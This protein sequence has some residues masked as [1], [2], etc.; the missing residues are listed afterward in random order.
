MS[1]LSCKPKNERFFKLSDTSSFCASQIKR[2]TCTSWKGG[3]E[4]KGAWH[5]NELLITATA[6]HVV[7]SSSGRND[8]ISMYCQ[9]TVKHLIPGSTQFNILQPPFDIE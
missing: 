7:T 1:M 8:V 4:N 9:L 6:L 3:E 5:E 2:C